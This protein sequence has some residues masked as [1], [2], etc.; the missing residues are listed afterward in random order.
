MLGGSSAINGQAFVSA[1]KGG[2][3]WENVQPY[4]RK[5]YTLNLPDEETR[6]HLGLK[7][8]GPSVHGFS[9]P[10]QA[11][12]PGE[13]Q[14]PLVKAWVDI[15]KNIGYEA[16]ADPYSGASL[17]TINANKEV[18]IT[19]GV[20]NT[21]KL[22]EL[23]VIGSEEILQKYNIPVVIHNPNVIDGV[24][25]GDPLLRQEPEAIQ[26]AMQMYSEHEPG[27]MTIGGVQSNALMPILEFTGAD[28]QKAQKKFFDQFLSTEPATSFQSVIRGIFETHNEATCDMFT[29]LAQANLHQTN[30]SYYVGPSSSPENYLSLGQTIDPRYFS[31]PLD[32]EILARNLLELERLHQNEALAKYFK[33]SDG[34]RNHLDSFLTDLE[35]AEKY[36]RDTVTT[37]HHF[38]GTA[39]MLPEDKGVSIFP[40]IPPANR[41]ATVYAVAERAADIIK[42]DA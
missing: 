10:I 18:V 5:S 8:V 13:V 30:T 17:I 20:L 33:M 27:P 11:S 16:T 28:G 7:W 21:P 12:F 6:E 32:I 23:S 40:I 35:L 42:A 29:F 3:T 15:S 4:Y 39:T 24:V 26:P 36:F 34:R 1:S 22:L 25:T 37:S 2:W 41:T 31:H 14:N 19:A 9:G 38:A